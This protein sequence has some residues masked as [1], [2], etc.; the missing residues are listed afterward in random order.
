MYYIFYVCSCVLCSLADIQ[1]SIDVTAEVDELRNKL[2]ETEQKLRDNQTRCWRM[3]TSVTAK[4]MMIRRLTQAEQVQ[5]C[6]DLN[7]F[8]NLNCKSWK[9][10]SI[11]LV[12]C[13][14]EIFQNLCWCKKHSCWCNSV[15]LR[16]GL[17]YHNSEQHFKNDSELLTLNSYL[18]HFPG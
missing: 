7:C 10:Y 11:F 2:A 18:L 17:A 4:E 15:L 5:I 9:S 8:L 13:W 14:L 12:V 16:Y 1:D 3:L 6:A